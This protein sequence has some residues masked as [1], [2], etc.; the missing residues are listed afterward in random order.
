MLRGSAIVQKRGCIIQNDDYR[1]VSDTY[2]EH[3]EKYKVPKFTSR[4]DLLADRRLQEKLDIKGKKDAKD[5]KI[6]SIKNLSFKDYYRPQ[7]YVANPTYTSIVQKNAEH[8]RTKR[9]EANLTAVSQDINTE[10]LPDPGLKWVN[11]DGYMSKSLLVDKRKQDTLREGHKFGP[12]FDTHINGYGRI[13]ERENCIARITYKGKS[14]SMNAQLLKEARMKEMVQDMTKKFGN[15]IL[16]VHGQELPKFAGTAD[17]FYWKK[18]QG[19]ADQPRCMS[20]NKLNQERKYWADDDQML[21]SDTTGQVA[22]DCP[23]K[24]NRVMPRK[25]K[26]FVTQNVTEKDDLLPKTDKIS[27]PEFKM[28]F[29]P[30][31]KWSEQD[32]NYKC[33]GKD[34]ALRTFTKIVDHAQKRDVADEEKMKKMQ[35]VII[36]QAPR[37]LQ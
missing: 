3:P 37:S 13:G 26:Y 27:P 24:I 12:M 17:R 18:Y 2:P 7:E 14:T 22:P 21:L 25:S 34:R 28:K 9:T 30:H 1:K 6:S 20:L 19:Y 33:E 16:G 8:K 29:K 31:I 35:E 32:K 23:F 10:K 4:T 15:Q 36:K 5:E 11:F